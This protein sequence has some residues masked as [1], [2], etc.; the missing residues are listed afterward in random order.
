MATA[1]T[2]AKQDP[3]LSKGFSW[4]AVTAISAALL[5]FTA[6]FALIF[7][8]QQIHDF[9]KAE[10]VHQLVEQMRYFTS[11]EFKQIRKTLADKRLDEH[12]KLLPL[13]ADAAPEEMYLILNFFEEIGLLEKKVT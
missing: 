2:P 9:R 6:L 5:T 3:D 12:G 11:T 4:E 8:W 10:Q 13:K 7:S 1:A